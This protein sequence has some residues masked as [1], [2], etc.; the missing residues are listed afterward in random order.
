MPSLPSL[1]IFDESSVQD[2]SSETSAT[3]SSPDSAGTS[4]AALQRI[5]EGDAPRHDS[6]S[7]AHTPRMIPV[8][9]SADTS[10]HPQSYGSYALPDIM[11]NETETAASPMARYSTLPNKHALSCDVTIPQDHL[12]QSSATSV[13]EGDSFHSTASSHDLTVYNRANASFDPA[14]G[15]QGI[16]RFNAGKLNSYLHGL[17]RRLQ[18]ENE[19]LLIRLKEK[20]QQLSNQWG[21]NKVTENDEAEQWLQEKEEMERKAS[22]NRELLQSLGEELQNERN[23]RQ[24]DKDKWKG[25]LAEV[26]K[27][28]GDIIKDLEKRATEAEA[29][30]EK[31]EEVLSQLA[32]K[33]EEL[34]EARKECK[35]VN[36]RATQAKDEQDGIY[37]RLRNAERESLERKDEARMLELRVRKAESDYEIV[38]S[39]LKD[40]EADLSKAEK[41]YELLKQDV[42][43]SHANQKIIEARLKDA[44]MDLER[45]EEECRFL[46][47][48]LEKFE[49]KSNASASVH[50]ANMTLRQPRTPGKPLTD[51]S[52][53]QYF[54]TVV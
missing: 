31:L 27:G 36:E 17:N 49:A 39:R 21:L 24:R 51:V 26:E 41:D 44:Q 19:A 35:A 13:K 37:S 40:M 11:E 6:M 48:C 38:Q 46:K 18:E 16:G 23:E 29:K 9:D 20:E 2:S 8:A 14:T 5:Y 12:F 30:A 33:E 34:R 47:Q 25:R 43:E 53:V 7:S 10:S 54:R 3:S 22:E 28:V 50:M 4:S 1:P 45:S 42:D 15:A 52:K 32:D